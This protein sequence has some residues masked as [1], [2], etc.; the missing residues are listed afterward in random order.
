MWRDICVAKDLDK[1]NTSSQIPPVKLK[2]VLWER[3]DA[4]SSVLA[5][6]EGGDL[7]NNKMVWVVYLFPAQASMDVSEIQVSSAWS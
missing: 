7:I 1:P 2:F 5:V 6:Y 4:V 3:F